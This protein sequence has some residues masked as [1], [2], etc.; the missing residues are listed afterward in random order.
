MA[1]PAGKQRSSRAWV[2]PCPAWQ[3]ASYINTNY[4]LRFLSLLYR[5]TLYQQ[6][7]CLDPPEVGPLRQG[8]RLLAKPWGAEPA[9]PEGRVLSSLPGDQEGQ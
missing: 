9:Q 6:C 5:P 8:L 2:S 1:S 4:L 7:G 3:A